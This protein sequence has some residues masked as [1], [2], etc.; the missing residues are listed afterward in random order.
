MN[1]NATL[2]GQMI[3]FA[4]FVWFTMRFVWPPITKA[5]EE[6]KDKIADG[7]ASAERGKRELELAQQRV[8]EELRQAKSK[9][10]DIIEHANVRASQLLDEAKEQTQK[11]INRLMQ[12]ARQNIDL[13]INKA[14]DA[15]RAQVATLAISG[16]E[17]IL[18]REVDK[19]TNESL[20][21]NMIAELDRG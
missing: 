10:N 3:T 14:R 16:A 8:T 12:D 11:E 4:L 7:L 17:K 1:I 6:R 9:A 5:L 21:Q 15:L 18:R 20:V 2:I 13:E 19:Q